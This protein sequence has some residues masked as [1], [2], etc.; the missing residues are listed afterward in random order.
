MT[1]HWVLWVWAI[2]ACGSSTPLPTPDA[3]PDAGQL[4][5]A[6][7]SVPNQDCVP[8]T[9]CLVIADAGTSRM[10]GV[11]IRGECDL[12]KQNCP[13]GQQCGYPPSA[14]GGVRTRRCYSASGQGLATEGQACTSFFDCAKGLVCITN[15]GAPTGFTCERYCYEERGCSGGRPCVLGAPYPGNREALLFCATAPTACDLVTQAPCVAPRACRL[16]DDLP[17]CQ[18]PGSVGLDGMCL[19]HSDCERGLLCTAGNCRAICDLDA[20]MPTC[21]SGTCRAASPYSATCQP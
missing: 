3:G 13:D 20:G 9:S 4:P 2:S 10:R 1:R 17:F 7:C 21:A 11:C 19:R 16:V 18:P 12:V 15:S 8:G 5:G 6:A 14:D